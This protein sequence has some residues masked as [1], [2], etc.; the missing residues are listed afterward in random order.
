[1]DA[2]DDDPRRSRIAEFLA[3][4]QN[5]R[6]LSPH[7]VSGYGCDL[8]ALLTELGAAPL[9]QLQNPQVR[10]AV[11]KLHARGLSG[12]SIGRTLSAWRT[13]YRWLDRWHGPV[14]NPVVGVRP[15]KSPKPLPKTLSPDAAAQL[16]DTPVSQPDEVRDKAMFELLY[17]S[18]LRLA[19]LISI[20]LA[21]ARD[22]RV[23]GE[24]V[25]TGKGSKT[26]RVPVGSKAV[27][28]LKAW[29]AVRALI[30]VP[31]ETALFV[32][33]RGRRIAP[34]VV[35]QRLAQWGRRLGLSVH[36]HMLRHS[37][38]THVLQSSSDL[39]AVQEMLGHAS[40]STTQVYTHLD[41]QHLA[42]VYD[43]AHPRAKKK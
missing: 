34:S 20:D 24:I 22:I 31:E 18:G 17:S 30:A 25:V 29:L 21:Q 1:M 38:A 19:E 4:L 5:E 39:R 14:A 35:E 36:P 23:D 8:E 12:H 6:R 40:I 2:G 43:Q 33:A 41:F 11:A 10:R 13:F 37:F 26:R 16:L 42:K 27:E 3:H 9:E 7:T 15:P 32:G 28:A